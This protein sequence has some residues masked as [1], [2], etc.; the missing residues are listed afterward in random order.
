ME[1]ID[2][3]RIAG[4]IFILGYGISILITGDGVFRGMSMDG[5]N[6]ILLGIITIAIGLFL[7]YQVIKKQR[8]K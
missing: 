1:A 5:K 2:K 3:F 8:Q 6:A 4:S 7:A